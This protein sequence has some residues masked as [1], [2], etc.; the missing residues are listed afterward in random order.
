M[1][2][3]ISSW[4]NSQGLRFPKDVMK[5]LHLA[6]GDKMKIVVENQ[7]IILKPIKQPREKLDINALVADIPD[8]Y[9]PY[10]VFDYSVGREEW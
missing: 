9:K 5:E 2:A 10:E 6:V 1:T 8:D 4:G 7:T 3:T